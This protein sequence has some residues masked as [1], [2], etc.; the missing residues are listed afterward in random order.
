[1]FKKLSTLSFLCM[2]LFFFYCVGLI[3]LPHNAKAQELKSA[4]SLEQVEAEITGL[5]RY[6]NNNDIQFYFFGMQNIDLGNNNTRSTVELNSNNEMIMNLSVLSLNKKNEHE[7]YKLLKVKRNRII[8]LNQYGEEIIL[9]RV[10]R[11]IITLKG[12]LAFR[13]RIALPDN[14]AVRVNLYADGELLNTLAFSPDSTLPIPF[15]LHFL[16]RKKYLQNTQLSFTASI[17]ANYELL[18]ETEEPILVTENYITISDFEYDREDKDAD[19][20]YYSLDIKKKGK[21][22]DVILS[23]AETK[24]EENMQSTQ[25]NINFSSNEPLENTYWRLI[26]LHGKD[27]ITFNNMPEPHLIIKGNKAYGSDGCNQYNLPIANLEN[28]SNAEQN[29]YL[30]FKKG[31]STMMLCHE[32]EEQALEFMQSLST[33]DNYAISG[34]K[35]YLNE[36][37][38]AKLIFEARPLK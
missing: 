8:L 7:P 16:G 15:T 13:E 37:L 6:K 11:D 30:N 28:T 4:K 10:D 27:I 35:L 26:S 36:D 5:W 24:I 17:Y 14:I 31:S 9:K 1:M 38:D 25:D 32:G 20:S 33:I 12:T 22:F 2:G 21:S 29:Q 19:G 3:T 18:F 23:Q 34:T